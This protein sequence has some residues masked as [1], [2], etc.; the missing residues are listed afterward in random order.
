MKM[1]LNAEE[2]EILKPIARLAARDFLGTQLAVVEKK[3]NKRR[4]YQE[5]F[6]E[7]ETLSKEETMLLAVYDQQKALIQELM[8]ASEEELFLDV[9]R[10][11]TAQ[12]RQ[13]ELAS[14]GKSK[15][16]ADNR[17][18]RWRLKDEGNILA[19]LQRQ[20]LHWLKER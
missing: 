6:C 17:T 13:R 2:K 4:A 3:I 14:S 8:Q 1:N 11:R 10:Q 9:L 19:E 18:E 16:S 7:G 5:R 12:T 15:S 20:W